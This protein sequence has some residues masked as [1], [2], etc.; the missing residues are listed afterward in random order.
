MKGN[1]SESD[2][3]ESIKYASYIQAAMLPD[4]NEFKK[5]LPESFIFYKP[6]DVLSGDFYWVLKKNNRIA[7]AAADCT[8]HG[9]PGA[10]MSIMGINYLNL[11]AS[12]SIPVTNKILNTLR[13]YLMKAMHQHGDMDEQKDG[14]DMSVCVIDLDRKHI[15]FSGANNPLIYFNKGNVNLIKGDRMPIGISPVEE[16]A[17]KK[18]IIPF[19]KIDSFYLFSDGYPDQFGGP[20]NKKL[21]NSGFRDLLKRINSLPFPRQEKELEEQLEKWMQQE[22]QTDDILVIGADLG[23]F[24]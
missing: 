18:H 4:I 11:V 6:R 9:V 8:G 19:T 23:S 14:I 1:L 3:N 13:E 2:I 7:I 15:E 20:D 17:F 22:Q 24:K 21:K 10:L 12:G 16:E 5:I